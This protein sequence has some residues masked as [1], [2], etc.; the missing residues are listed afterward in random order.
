MRRRRWT[1]EETNDLL[2]AICELDCV[3]NVQLATVTVQM[4]L[5][6]LRSHHG[7]CPR[8]ESAILAKIYYLAKGAGLKLVDYLVYIRE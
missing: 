4:R 7:E 3:E 8:S 5:A 1:E 6:E 2:M